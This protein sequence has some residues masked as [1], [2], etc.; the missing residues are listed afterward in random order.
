[1]KENDEMR[2]KIMKYDT[3]I[4]DLRQIEARGKEME[5]RYQQLQKDMDKI[6]GQLRQKTLDSD[7]YKAMFQQIENKYKNL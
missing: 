7:Q 5:N 2:H 3:L 6:N 4:Q 1:M